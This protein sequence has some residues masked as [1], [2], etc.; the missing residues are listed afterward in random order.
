M[1]NAEGRF[2]QSE[3]HIPRLSPSAPRVGNWLL[4]PGRSPDA[5][6]WDL[7]ESFSKNDVCFITLVT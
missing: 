6:M 2:E 3:F 7:K 5:L 1:S 4:P